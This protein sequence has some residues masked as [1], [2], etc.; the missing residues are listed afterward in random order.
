MPCDDCGTPTTRGRNQAGRFC[1][2]CSLRRAK[3]RNARKDYGWTS[4]AL[5]PS[6]RALAARDNYICHVCDGPVDM[7]LPHNDRMAPTRDHIVPRYA[8]GSHDPSNLKLAHRGC[9]SRRGAALPA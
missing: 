2:R 3:E 7:T 9:N 8:G 5:L 1:A 6:V 4:S